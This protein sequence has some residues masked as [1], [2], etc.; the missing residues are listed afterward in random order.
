MPLQ[1]Y[2]GPPVSDSRL[3]SQRANFVDGSTLMQ[4]VSTRTSS[5]SVPSRPSLPEFRLLVDR[6]LG[7]RRLDE[8]TVRK[9]WSDMPTFGYR[10]VFVEDALRSLSFHIASRKREVSA[11]DPP[12]RVESSR[13]ENQPIPDNEVDILRGQIG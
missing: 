8:S 7:E 6:R 13:E 12:P 9:A 1:T 10:P 2:Y 4:T 5:P 3:T 11:A